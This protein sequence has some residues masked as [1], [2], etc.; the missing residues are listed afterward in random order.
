MDIP[1]LVSALAVESDI[2]P[3]SPQADSP[4]NKIAESINIKTLNFMSITPLSST[5]F[6]QDLSILAI[7]P[8]EW[9]KAE[10][11]ALLS[12]WSFSSFDEC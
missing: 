1:A 11:L 5:A 4:I 3:L 6:I 10:T 9:L 8:Q 12:K 7:S 2:S